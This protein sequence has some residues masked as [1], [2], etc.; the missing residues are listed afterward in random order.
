VLF[1]FD[2]VIADTENHHI[3]AWQ[4]TL[5]A[6][7]WVVDEATCARAMEV[8]DRVFLAELFARREVADGDVEGWVRRKQGL[9]LTLLRDAPR[10]YPGVVEL[11]ARLR[12]RVRLGVVTTTWRANVEAVL[13]AAGLGDA[14]GLVVGKEDVKATKPDPEG[15]RKAVSRLKVAPADA[16]ALEDSASGLAA[17]R[18]AGL[19]ALAVGH[20]LP[21]R[22]LGGAVAVPGCLEPDGR[23][24]GGPRCHTIAGSE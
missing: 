9:T 13:A 3:A 7:G 16:V 8:D 14:F 11:V 5:A 20:R 21:P 22:R 4:R 2:G 23:G 24:A 19:R 6:M 12:G 18:A 1:D 10:V 15:Y 17:A